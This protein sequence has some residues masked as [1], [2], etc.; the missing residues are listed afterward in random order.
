MIVPVIMFEMSGSKSA[1]VSLCLP[2]IGNVRP[3]GKGAFSMGSRMAFP[4]AMKDLEGI[5]EDFPDIAGN[6]YRRG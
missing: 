6:V 5:I 1:E 4:V 3:I 2:I